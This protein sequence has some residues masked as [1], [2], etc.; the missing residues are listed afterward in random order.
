M[1]VS[2][3]R[4]LSALL[5][6]ARVGA[7]PDRPF[8][9]PEMSPRRKHWLALSLQIEAYLHPQCLPPYSREQLLHSHRYRSSGTGRELEIAE[10]TPRGESSSRTHSARYGSGLPLAADPYRTK[11]PHAL[12][13]SQENLRQRVM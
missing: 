1:R 5:Q 10:I 6:P 13:A 4:P 11:S 8:Q 3:P 2:P 7:T 9:P 12:S